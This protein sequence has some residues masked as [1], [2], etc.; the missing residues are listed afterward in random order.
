M[1]KKILV[2]DDDPVVIEMLQSGLSRSGYEVVIARQGKE[3]IQKVREDQPSLVVLDV[4][5]P[6]MDGTE[7]ATI[8]RENDATQKIPIIYITVLIGKIHPAE[9]TPPGS[10]T[11]VLGKPFDLNELLVKINSFIG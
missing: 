7:V 9:Q 3:A 11:V 6:D 10:N 1:R 4:M 8:L 2:V 5:L